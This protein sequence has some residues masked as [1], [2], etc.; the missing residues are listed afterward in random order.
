M[1]L[2]DFH[3]SECG[4]DFEEL[5]S[6]LSDA[7]C[8]KCASAKVEKQLSRFSVGGSS[9]SSGSSEGWSPCSGGSCGTG[10]C[11]LA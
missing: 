1:K 4:K 3:C 5:V 2:Y 8:P 10:G 11:G 9:S 6:Q 7:R